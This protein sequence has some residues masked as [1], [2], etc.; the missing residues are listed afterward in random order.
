VELAEQVAGIGHWRLDAVSGEVT[1]SAQMYEIYDLNPDAPLDLDALQAMTHPDDRDAGRDRLRRALFEGMDSAPAL[2]R[3]VRPDGELRYVRGRMVAE[4]APDGAVQAV[5]GTLVDVTEYRLAAMEVE[6]AQER[7]KL[8]A[9]NANDL[10]LQCDL[11]GRVAFASPSSQRLTGYEPHEIV[12]RIWCGMISPADSDRV[13]TA[14][15][16]QAAAGL[17]CRSEPLEYRF[18]HRDGTIRW[19]EGMPTLV[20]DRDSGL[21]SGFTSIIRDV[22]VRRAAETELKAA[23]AEAEAAAAAKAEFL[24]NMSHELRTPLT[25]IIGFTGLASEQPGLDP[26]TRSYLERV[27]N[28]SEALLC[29]VNDVLDFS[30]LEAGQISLKCRPTE[31]SRLAQQTLDLF[32]PQV[33]AKDLALT[34]ETNI[35][36]L[37]VLVD[38]DR[39]RQIL[40]NLVGNAVKFTT[41][42][43]ITLRAH[44]EAAGRLTVEIID[45]GA[46]IA[47][48]KQNALFQRFSQVDGSLTRT[49]GGTGLGLAICKG[50]VEAMGGRIGLESELGAG[51]RFWFV[52]PAPAAERAPVV[53]AL[54]GERVLI[55]G[56]RVLVADDHPANRKLAGLFLAGVGAE[57]AE[58]VNGEEAV[59][60]ASEWPY[61]V[62]LMDIRMPKLDGPGALRAIRQTPGPNDT[63][64]ILAFTADADGSSPEWLA[65]HGF[66][67]CVTKPLEP[68]ALLRAIAAVTAP[69]AI[70][71]PLDMAAAV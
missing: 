30:K 50:L 39:I 62:I 2:T 37:V 38:P 6:R 32:G 54:P 65:E 31:F 22:T 56:V 63:I 68:G 36:D 52:I 26:L 59:R 20:F 5:I 3:V 16:E 67:G 48:D 13:F 19:L 15:R 1:W 61:D 33:G 25:S 46:G 35:D 60:M 23:R 47:K 18:I 27:T 58:A 69:S 57:V 12:G 24:A 34:F 53:A 41:A 64:P 43:G 45:T 55:E 51:S 42:G 28:A 21:P 10:V 44:Y 71:S 8:L 40:L 29:T 17:R 49:H 11:D 70:D 4:R 9:D 7:Y 14:I 66:Q